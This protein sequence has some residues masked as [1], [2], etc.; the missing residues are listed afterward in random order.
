MCEGTHC[1][2]V[3]QSGNCEPGHTWR[4]AASEVLGSKCEHH[5]QN[6]YSANSC[7]R[8]GRALGLDDRRV[9]R[10]PT[11]DDGL[12]FVSSDSQNRFA[13]RMRRL[14]R[15]SITMMPLLAT[16]Y[17]STIAPCR[18]EQCWSPDYKKAIRS[19]DP[20]DRQ[21]FRSFYRLNL[22]YELAAWKEEQCEDVRDQDHG[23]VSTRA[24]VLLGGQ[25]HGG[26]REQAERSAG[27]GS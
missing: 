22:P 11:A 10:E 2:I 4:S 17:I 14:L 7:P 16:Q 5:L 20:L 12:E 26:S 27:L 1:D 3:G 9:R 8:D 23:S 19:Y 6:P 18:L 24:E 25:S 21:T 13:V 15:N